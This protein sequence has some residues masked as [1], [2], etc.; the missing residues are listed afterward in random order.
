MT[1]QARKLSNTGIYHIIMRGN[2][3]KNVF[4]DSD[5][6]QRFLDGIKTKREESSFLLYAYCLMD[7]HVHL[8]LNTNHADLAEIMKSIAVRY[9]SFYNW[10]YNRVGHVFQDRFKSEP[11]EDDRY[12]LAVVRYIH[13][14][15]IKAGMVGKL[16]DY[17]WSSFP[18]YIQMVGTTWLDVTFVLGLFADNQMIAVNEFKKFSM[19]SD[20]TPFPDSEDE[21][22]IRTLEEGRAYLEEYL[23]NNAIV[24]EIGQLKENKQIRSEVIHHL[25]AKTSLSQR[26]IARLLG[27]NKNTVER[28]K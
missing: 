3:R 25:R 8:L 24:K 6:K 13:N 23:V 19:E 27:I 28:N 7:N 11:I 5:D 4:E 12:L 16:A 14:N 10:K 22:P 2:E 17:E 18:K 26:T 15:P 9:A 20:N 21:K 1:R